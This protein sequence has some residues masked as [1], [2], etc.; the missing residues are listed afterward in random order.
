MRDE[1]ERLEREYDQLERERVK[2]IKLYEHYHK[3]M[4]LWWGRGKFEEHLG[5]AEKAQHDR[6]RIGSKITELRQMESKSLD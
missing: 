1:I 3:K 6:D 2:Q 5:L 4:F